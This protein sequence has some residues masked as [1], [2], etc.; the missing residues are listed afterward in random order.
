M[1]IVQSQEEYSSQLQVLTQK[2]ESELKSQESSYKTKIVA[3]ERTHEKQIAE[4]QTLITQKTVELTEKFRVEL[5]TIKAENNEEEFQKKLG[6]KDQRIKVL[7]GYLEKDP[8]ANL[9][10]QKNQILEKKV[11]GLMQFL[12]QERLRNYKL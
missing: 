7:E 9:L 4:Q 10:I 12:E 8:E 6:E 1:Q 3:M 2:F 5:E 11:T